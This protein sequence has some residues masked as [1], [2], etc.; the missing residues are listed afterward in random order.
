[1]PLISQGEVTAVLDIDSEN[2]NNFSEIDGKY[3]ERVAEML[4]G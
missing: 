2:E 1:V 4:V 3:L